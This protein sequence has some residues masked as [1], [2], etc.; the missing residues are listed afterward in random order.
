MV[1]A[2]IGICHIELN[3]LNPQELWDSNDSPNPSQKTRSCICKKEE[4]ITV[5]FVDP[6][7]HRLELNESEN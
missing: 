2:Q 1:Y 6:T 4:H 3:S 5:E 7:D